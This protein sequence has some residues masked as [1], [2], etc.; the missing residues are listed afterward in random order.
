M[1]D[2]V[3]F[4]LLAAVALVKAT[5]PE[6]YQQQRNEGDDF[7]KETPIHTTDLMAGRARTTLESS[8]TYTQISKGIPTPSDVEI[9]E[10]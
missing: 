4:A 8:P 7:W 6:D 1:K 5:T 9:N 3:T 2:V 10:L